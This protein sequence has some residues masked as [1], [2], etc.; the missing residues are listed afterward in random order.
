[1]K[2]THDI[3]N[4]IFNNQ[5][6]LK[7]NKDIIQLSKFNEVIPMFDIYSMK[8]YPIKNINI[9]FRMID[10]HYRFINQEIVDWINNMSKKNTNKD[11]LKKNLRV[12][13]NYNIETLYETSIN[14]FF[15]FSPKFGL[16]I[17]ICKRNSFHSKMIHIT[18]YYSKK[19]LI[20]L[21][22]NMNL[23]KKE[24]SND[25]LDK[26]THYRI[27][28]QISKNDI[29]IDTIL[30]HSNYIV[31]NDLI[32]LITYYSLN[33]SFLMNKLL[34]DSSNKSKYY[35]P[36]QIKN[37]NTLINKINL[38]PPLPNDYYF[39]RF[40]WE[41]DFLSKLKVGEIFTDSGFTSTTR[42][43]FYS[44]GTNYNF[45][46]V[47]LKINIPK[48]VKGIGLFIENFS[49]FP[50]EEEF[51]M[52]PGSK[53][54]L[55]SK[56]NNFK[57]H[58]LNP[59][60]ERLVKKKYEFTWIGKEKKLLNYPKKENYSFMN[61]F[62]TVNKN[63]LLEGDTL[64]ERI[65]FLVKNYSSNF[66]IKIKNIVCQIN[67]F[68]G[69]SSYK[70]FYYNNNIKGLVLNVILDNNI[71]TSIECGD[72][73]IVNYILSKYY[74]KETKILMELYYLIAKLIGYEKFI[75]YDT[76]KN[77]DSKDVFKINKKYNK[78]L[79]TYFKEKKFILDK[80]SKR[81]LGNLKLKIFFNQIDKELNQKYGKAE[82]H[83]L[84]DLYEY[85]KENNYFYLNKIHNYML[86][87][88]GKE[89]F[90]TIVNAK[91]YWIDN[92]EDFTSY[93]IEKTKELE[94]DTSF[95]RRRSR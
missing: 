95:N 8:V 13:K 5:L 46:L 79:L 28:K 22:A 6:T 38:A 76:F 85:V 80:Y 92:N 26:N 56:D 39:Y 53:L 81:S 12:L 41:D 29:S 7:T 17:S 77:Y 43:P 36:Q 59:K 9:H 71:I 24:T 64:L 47:L 42:D 20:K 30:E 34:R 68:D 88:L 65:E 52:A 37:I 55:V 87:N 44:P 57:Y 54:K 11:I 86:D 14:T 27:C 18:P 84:S 21:G 45:G 72:K 69:T 63:T 19:E 49:L 32:M 35:F 33:G 94:Y 48:K 31:T 10:C 91:Q 3:I 74:N 90:E 51:L 62:I 60:F 58:H 61:Q 75:I 2:I 93:S 82:N 67:W 50:I 73:M 66:H 1:M 83:K 70:D 23:L 15:K 78:T 25:L 89:I 16:E 4:K 40:I